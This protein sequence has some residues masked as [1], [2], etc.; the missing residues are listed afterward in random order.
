[1]TTRTQPD[2]LLR[3][4]LFCLNETGHEVIEHLR[5]VKA[6]A[7]RLE[8][9]WAGAYFAKFFI[10]HAWLAGFRLRLT[11]YFETGDE[12][13]QYRTSSLSVDE[14]TQLAGIEVAP[15]L[16]S[17]GE[18]DAGFAADI[19]QDQLDEYG[20]DVFTAFFEDGNPGELTLSVQR[21][22]FDTLLEA[23][24]IEGTAAFSALFREWSV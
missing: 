16:M 11:A 24:E 17:G 5:Q 19:L 20:L 1:M 8:K 18:F 14:V 15:E 12:G 13:E 4:G 6:A 7:A 10:S 22:A 9:S 3:N 21:S 23:P 2:Y